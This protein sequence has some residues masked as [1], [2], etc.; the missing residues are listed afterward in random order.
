MEF[1]DQLKKQF[2][3]II[4]GRRTKLALSQ[5]ELAFRSDLSPETISNIENAKSIANLETIFKL[6]KGFNINP[7]HLV[8]E[9][10]ER[11]Q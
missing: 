7:G 6:A 5:E 11:L 3:F 8:N 1:Q 9:V 10:Y 2:A 4:K